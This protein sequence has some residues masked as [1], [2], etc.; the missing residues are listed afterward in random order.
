[1]H[2]RVF[3]TRRPTL[4]SRRAGDPGRS[5]A[6]DLDGQQQR[7]LRGGSKTIRRDTRPVLIILGGPSD[8][9]YENGKRDY[10]NLPKLTWPIMMFKSS[11]SRSGWHLDQSAT[12]G[13]CSDVQL[14]DSE[15]ELEFNG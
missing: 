10:D 12:S 2:S 5:T 11:R 14:C 15:A 7:R 6:H 9:A 13:T 4:R 1:M 8:I 3:R